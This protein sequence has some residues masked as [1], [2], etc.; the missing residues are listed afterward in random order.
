[1][2]KEREQLFTDVQY[3][4]PKVTFHVEESPQRIRI[5]RNSAPMPN[6]RLQSLN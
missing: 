3:Y 6:T 2:I 1:M 5:Q 4:E